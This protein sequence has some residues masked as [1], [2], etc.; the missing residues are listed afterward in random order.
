[1]ATHLLHGDRAILDIRKIEGYC[2]SPLHSRGRHKARVFHQALGLQQSDAAW[3]REALLAA[4]ASG[5]AEPVAIDA[6][7]DTHWR[8]DVT[9]RRHRRSAVVRSFRIVRTGENLPRFMTCWVL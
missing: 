8:L 3:L 9:I 6:W 7:G 4:A 2:L 5:V 1:M